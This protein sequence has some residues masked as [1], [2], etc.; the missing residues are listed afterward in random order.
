MNTIN[1]CVCGQ[2]QV[3]VEGIIHVKKR[4]HYFFFSHEMSN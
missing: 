1:G 2:I 3:Y 4:V